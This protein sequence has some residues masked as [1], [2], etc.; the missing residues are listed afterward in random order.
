MY[1]HIRMQTVVWAS[2]LGAV[3]VGV[4]CSTVASLY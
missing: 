4:F 3:S 1:I 2:L